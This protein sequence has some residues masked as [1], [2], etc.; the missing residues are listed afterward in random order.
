M[1]Y[2]VYVHNARE[3]AV[4]GD[5]SPS[6]IFAAFGWQSFPANRNATSPRVWTPHL[7]RD[8]LP[9]AKF[10]VMLR[11]PVNRCRWRQSSMNVNLNW[12]FFQRFFRMFS[13]YLHFN[14]NQSIDDFHSR[15]VKAVNSVRRCLETSTL[16]ECT[17]TLVRN[18]TLSRTTE[19]WYHYFLFPIHL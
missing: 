3:D 15:C 1:V 11:N 8:L 16:R 4:S 2:T 5:G 13:D 10:L 19:V 6:T 7:L 14:R 17:F 9:D 18:P 12:R